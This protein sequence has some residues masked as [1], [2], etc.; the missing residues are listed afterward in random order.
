MRLVVLLIVFSLNVFANF[1][2]NGSAE[3]YIKELLDRQFH[4]FD[5]SDFECLRDRKY[6]YIINAYNNTGEAQDPP[7]SID[8]KTLKITKIEK[9]KSLLELY[10]VEY[11]VTTSSGNIIK[12]EMSITVTG[13]TRYGCAE[14][15]L[16]RPE[17]LI[18]QSC[19]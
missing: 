8:S 5:Q 3:E 1:Q 10:R 18:D 14:I 16:G 6:K 13:S 12:E 7:T 9:V 17:G 11:E 2:C 15:F 4:G 19:Y